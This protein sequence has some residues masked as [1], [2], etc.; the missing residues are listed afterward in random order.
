M[1]YQRTYEHEDSTE[2]WTYDTD[3]FRNGPISVE[4]K[5]KAG[6]SQ[7]C[8]LPIQEYMIEPSFVCVLFVSAIFIL[9][10]FLQYKFRVHP[11]LLFL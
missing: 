10:S 1:K 5:Y 8:I 6:P 11:I 3:K 7:Q 2:V 9:L 4:I